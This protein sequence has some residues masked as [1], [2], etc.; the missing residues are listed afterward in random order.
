MASLIVRIGADL[1]ELEAGLSRA[2]RVVEDAGSRMQSL[3]RTIS[4]RVTAPLTA[5]GAVAVRAFGIQEQAEMK[6][7]AALQANGREVNN[8]FNRYNE[9][10][11]EMQRVTVVGDEATLAMLA[12]AESLGVT[13]DSAERAVRNSIAMQS[14]FGVSAERALRYTAALEQGNATML[15][16]YIPALRGIED[17]SERAAEAQRILAGAFQSAEAEA[18]STSGQF[19]QM[20]NAVGDL[21]EDIGEII[22]EAILPF[23]NRLQQLAEA[24]QQVDRAKMR[25]AV[26]IGGVTAALGPLLIALGTLIKMLAAVMTPLLA[27]IAAVGLLVAAFEYVRRNLDVFINRIAIGFAKVRNIVI[28]EVDRILEVIQQWA[29][30]MPGLTEV[31]VGQTRAALRSLTDDIPEIEG[32]FQSMGEFITGVM[33]DLGV[34]FDDF[35]GMFSRNA[36]EIVDDE[37]IIQAIARPFETAQQRAESALSRM[38]FTTVEQGQRIS[39]SWKDTTEGMVNMSDALQQSITSAASSFAE[40]IGQMIASGGDGQSFFRNMIN[41]VADFAVQFGRIVVAMGVAALELRNLFSNPFAAIAAGS[42]L[43]ALGSAARSLV[44]AGPGGGGGGGTA[45][46][47]EPFARDAGGQVEFRIEYDSLVGVLD[48]GDRRRGRVG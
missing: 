14:A 15:N 12:Q 20:R 1:K 26:A 9:F 23:V 43:I 48:N 46:N 45:A 41:I 31:A 36:D 42:A 16:R 29:F 21:M 38:E 18:Q 6:L 28:D 34:L 35:L 19:I 11:Q 32:E 33:S 7:R 39:D 5:L 47:F 8:L 40:S 4:T 30:A 37:G 10:A 2:S 25:M 17:E 27:K 22:A 13:G 3:G 24:A 44:A